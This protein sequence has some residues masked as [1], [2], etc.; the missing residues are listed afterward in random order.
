M[1]LKDALDFNPNEDGSAGASPSPSHGAHRTHG[2]GE[3]PAELP[4]RRKP[5]AGVYDPNDR[6]LIVFITVCTKS[7]RPLLANAAMHKLLRDAWTEADNWLVGRYVIMPDHVHLFAS[8]SAECG[9]TLNA[10]MQ[11]WKSLFTKKLRTSGR[12]DI[13]PHFW[14]SLQWDR[15]LRSAEHYDEKWNYVAANPVRHGLVPNAADW[16]YQGEL[17]VLRF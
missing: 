2:E 8:P 6:A 4:K 7:R 1:K 15:R 3:A 5:A 14:E 11:Y 10:W 16:P 12:K 17:S 9:V 13:P